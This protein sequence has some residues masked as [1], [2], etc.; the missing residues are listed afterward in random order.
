MAAENKQMVQMENTIQELQAQLRSEL[1]TYNLKKLELERMQFE[2]ET[3]A[4]NKGAG[5]SAGN[6]TV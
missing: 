4:E 1:A 6:Y 5:I 3:K 2:S